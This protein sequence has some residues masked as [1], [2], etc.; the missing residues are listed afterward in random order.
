MQ[1]N[2]CHLI[3]HSPS[4]PHTLLTMKNFDQSSDNSFKLKGSEQ[5]KSE[6]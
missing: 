6:F 2:R 4:A 1:G 5:G 3:Q